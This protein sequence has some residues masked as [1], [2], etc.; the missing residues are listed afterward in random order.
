MKGGKHLTLTGQ[1]WIKV[2]NK[3]HVLENHPRMCTSL[4][5]ESRIQKEIENLEADTGFKLRVLAQSYPETPGEAVSM[6]SRLF[7]S[8]Q[9]CGWMFC[10]PASAPFSLAQSLKHSFTFTFILS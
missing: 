9:A 10:T 6:Q 8:F 2:T 4:L 3:T 5:Q 1:R 7:V